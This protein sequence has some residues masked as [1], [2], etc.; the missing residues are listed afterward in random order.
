MGGNVGFVTLISAIGQF[1]G[2]LFSG[3]AID[4][5]ALP[6]KGVFGR[7]FAAFTVT[8][9]IM[10]LVG[11]LFILFRRRMGIADDRGPDPE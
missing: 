4:T 3:V 11:M 1:A 5:A 6:E 9:I 7:Y 2:T 8:G 10:V